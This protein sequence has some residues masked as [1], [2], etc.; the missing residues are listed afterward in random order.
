[1]GEDVVLTQSDMDISNFG[2]ALD[3]RAVVF[4][5][6]TIQALPRTLAEFTLL[7]TTNFAKA[8]SAYV[9]DAGHSAALLASANFAS[10]N[11]VR[12]YLSRG[13]DDLGKFNLACFPLDAEPL[14]SPPLASLRCRWERQ[15]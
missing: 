15:H 3:G 9:F 6:A 12:I 1:M 10:L 2:I 5:A 4:D 7:R 8:V 13:N 11:E 14:P